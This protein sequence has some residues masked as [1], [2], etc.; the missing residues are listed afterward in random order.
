MSGPHSYLILASTCLSPLKTVRENAPG[1]TPRAAADPQLHAASTYMCLL[2]L[3]GDMAISFRHVPVI[4]PNIF[5][6][7][8]FL[9]CC[10]LLDREKELTALQ[11]RY[12]E[13]SDRWAMRS[14][15]GNVNQTVTNIR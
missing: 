15:A 3:T 10:R 12:T 4:M 9:A 6:L 1:V 8:G 2:Q 14:T 7:I 13:T 11:K 5:H